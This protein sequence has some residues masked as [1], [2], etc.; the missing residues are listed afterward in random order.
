MMYITRMDGNTIYFSDGSKI[1]FTVAD[2]TEGYVDFNR[3]R[4]FLEGYETPAQSF[5]YTK[6]GGYKVK[7]SP[8]PYFQFTGIKIRRHDPMES[9]RFFNLVFENVT[10]E[11]STFDRETFLVAHSESGAEGPH[12]MDGEYIDKDGNVLESVSFLMEG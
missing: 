4:Y 8:E 6:K 5:S 7:Y 11:G 1:V 12:R 2:G 3:V 10:V 9:S